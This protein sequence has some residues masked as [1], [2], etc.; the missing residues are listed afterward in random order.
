MSEQKAESETK[1]STP[2]L[3]YFN[4]G[5]EEFDNMIRDVSKNYYCM[6]IDFFASWCGPCKRLSNLLPEMAKNH[7]NLQFVKINVDENQEVSKLFSVRSLP[8]VKVFQIKG[9][10]LDLVETII[11]CNIRDIEDAIETA[12]KTLDP[13]ETV[14]CNY[15]Y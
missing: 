15:T 7:T 5:K 1:S 12:F 14:D 13:P 11:G 8:T 6:L 2:N 10:K 9:D 3:M 4:G